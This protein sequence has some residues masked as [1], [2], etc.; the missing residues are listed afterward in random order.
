MVLLT[1]LSVGQEA[2]VLQLPAGKH[3]AIGKQEQEAVPIAAE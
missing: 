1:R 2:T 3:I